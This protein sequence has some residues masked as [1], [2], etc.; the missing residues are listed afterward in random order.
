MK[1]LTLKEFVS[2][3]SPDDCRIFHVGHGQWE[4]R[5]QAGVLVQP[6]GKTRF[7]DLTYLLSVLA[8]VGIRCT[9]IEWDGLPAAGQQEAANTADVPP[10]WAWLRDHLAIW[11]SAVCSR[12]QGEKDADF[13][14]G[15]L[16]RS[17][18]GPKIH[19]VAQIRTM[20]AKQ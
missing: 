13:W 19:P 1:Q 10:S 18:A 5:C 9:V 12:Q 7:N 16:D 14:E 2:E 15:E 6:N 8:S 11:L 4:V 20:T 17:A 3:A